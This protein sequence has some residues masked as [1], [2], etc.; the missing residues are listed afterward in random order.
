MYSVGKFDALLLNLRGGVCRI[1]TLDVHYYIFTCSPP[2]HII[3][4]IAIF[5]EKQEIFWQNQG[6]I[7]GQA[8]EKIF[9]QVTSAPPPP[10]NETGPVRLWF[11]SLETSL[12]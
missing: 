11:V 1:M 7:F 10:P 9:G 2:P 12:I 4:L 6:L 8:M 5:G 3:F